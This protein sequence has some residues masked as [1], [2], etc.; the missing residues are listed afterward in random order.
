MDEPR[1][2]EYTH[3][4]RRPRHDRLAA[5]GDARRTSVSADAPGMPASDD[6]ESSASTPSSRP[7]S[8]GRNLARA[9]RSG[10]SPV[11]RPGTLRA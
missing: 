7:L 8:G 5:A 2:E 10:H 6:M 4:P 1:P 11:A 9:N 3:H